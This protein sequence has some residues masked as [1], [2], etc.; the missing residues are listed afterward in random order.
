M[1]KD[2]RDL[3]Q[4]RK[5]LNAYRAGDTAAL[6]RV[7]RVYAPYV[8]SI[9]RRGVFGSDGHSRGMTAIEIVQDLV[10]DVFVRVLQPATRER[11]DG[12]R[13]FAPFLAAITRHVLLD[14]LRQ[15]ARRDKREVLSSE[16]AELPAWYPGD[17]LPDE[18]AITQQQQRLVTGF[19][20]TLE[21]TEQRFVQLRFKE[22]QSQRDVAAQL[23][24]GRQQV[25]NA[26]EKIR[27]RF[28]AYLGEKRNPKG[29]Q[30]RREK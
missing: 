16:S 27:K 13:P 1:S 9:L 21:E 22:G 29:Q 2:Q 3:S 7:F 26:E 30:Q 14:Y 11:Y 8:A 17:P 10:Q 18:T 15:Q 4:D 24:L 19:L 6:E 23:D 25:R 20:Q 28:R 5:W 12:L